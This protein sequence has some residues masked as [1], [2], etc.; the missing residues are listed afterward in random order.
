MSSEAKLSLYLVDDEPDQIFLIA[1]AAQR[2]GEFGQVRTATDA[3]L[4]YHQLLELSQDL[5]TRPGLVITD[6]KMPRMT[7]AQLACALRE[8]PSLR[9]IPVIA[10]SSSDSEADRQSAQDCG[11]RAFYQKPTGFKN[12]VELLRTIRQT[13][14]SAPVVA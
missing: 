14:V 11:C 1:L 12:L 13:H 2:C 9:A 5:E 8:H 6:W 4:A 3:Q 7:G 10:L